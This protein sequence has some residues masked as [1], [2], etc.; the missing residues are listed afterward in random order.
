[1]RIAAFLYRLFTAGL[2]GAQLFFAA[3]AAQVVF[4]SEIAALPH[5]DPRRVYAANAIGG[6]IERL[7]AATILGCALAVLCAVLLARSEGSGARRAALFPLL[8]GACAAASAFLITPAI[9][10]LRLANRTAEPAFARLHALSGLLL[11]LELIFL[12][13]AVARAPAGAPQS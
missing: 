8:A 6:M 10:A 7:D 5:A 9:H 3:G 4:S 12:L 11:L 13:V 2:F 1:M